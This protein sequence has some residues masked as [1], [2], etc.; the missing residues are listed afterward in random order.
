LET[1]KVALN[2]PK[3]SHQIKLL[4][5]Q[6]TGKPAAL[7]LALQEADGEILVLTDGDVE[8]GEKSIGALLKFFENPRI[9]AVSGRPISTNSR[10]DKFGFWA[11]VLT[12]MAHKTRASRRK[13]GEY[14]DCSGYLYAIRAGLVK[15]IPENTLSDDALISSLIYNLGYEIAYAPE[16][17]VSVKYPDNFRDWLKQKK[18]STGGYAQNFP[19][20]RGGIK[21]GGRKGKMRGFR[22][23]IAGIFQIFKYA[24]TPREFYWTIL[25][26]FARIILWLAIFWEIKIIKKPFEQMWHRVESTKNLP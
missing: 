8:I 4:K 18:R 26:I 1:Q 2:Y 16:A 12:E 23:E 9:G 6:G 10:A 21:G 14:L 13:K 11:Y 20:A 22:Q 17:K 7:N 19:P 5:D 15:N 25:L 24:K 3:N